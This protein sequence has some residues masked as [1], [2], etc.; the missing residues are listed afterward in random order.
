MAV[1]IPHLTAIR[2]AISTLNVVRYQ[3][4]RRPMIDI[5]DDTGMMLAN[6]DHWGPSFRL[7]G[8]TFAYP[9]RPSAAVLEIVSIEFPS[10]K[11]TAIVGASGCGNSSIVSLLMREYD[12]SHNQRL[13][14]S[15]LAIKNHIQDVSYGPTDQ[16]DSLDCKQAVVD[17][18][19]AL[20][21]GS[22]SVEFAGHDV[23]DL[24]LRWLR[25][26]ISVVKQ[27]PQLFSGTVFENVA[28]GLNGT[29]LEYHAPTAREPRRQSAETSREIRERCREAL[30]KAEAW[31]SSKSSPK[32]WIP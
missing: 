8:V 19:H 25:R 7:R 32:A 12:P 13:R 17:A 9:T 2:E 4:E 22:G 26:Q 14:R 24:N 20:V 15:D 28:D 21:P 3:I 23:R 16:V 29:L 31:S 1:I 6:S 10:S 27:D 11:F 18:A 5:T 30:I